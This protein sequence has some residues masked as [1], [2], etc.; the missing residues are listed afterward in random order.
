MSNKLAFGILQNHTLNLKPDKLI[1]HIEKRLNCYSYDPHIIT[2]FEGLFK[3]II[4]KFE[5]VDRID[6]LSRAV[7]VLSNIGGYRLGITVAPLIDLVSPL[8]I[9]LLSNS[10]VEYVKI[11]VDFYR[12]VGRILGPRYIFTRFIAPN[13]EDESIQKTLAIIV[14]QLI[15]DNP[16][17]EFTNDDFGEWIKTL[18]KLDGVGPRL[19]ST[20]K[21]YVNISDNENFEPD[22]DED[23]IAIPRKMSNRNSYNVLFSQNL[24]LNNKRSTEY[25]LPPQPP[26]VT[27]S[28]TPTSLFTKMKSSYSRTMPMRPNTHGAAFQ[29]TQR[30]QQIRKFNDSPFEEDES[31]REIVVSVRNG[32]KSKEWD[33]RCTAYNLARRVLKY[34]TDSFNDDDVHEMVTFILDDVVSVRAALQLAAISAIEELFLNKTEEMEIELARVLPILLRLHSKT[35]QFFEAALSQCCNIVVLSMPSKRFCSVL[36]AIGES[37]SQKVQAASAD[38]YCKSITKAN[39][40]KEK[41]FSKTSD[42]FIYLIK[43]VNKMLNGVSPQIRESARNIVKQLYVFYGDDLEKAAQKNLSENDVNHFLQYT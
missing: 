34:S 11:G 41:F 18:I 32:M 31:V 42:E 12:K 4:E 3:F 27:N 36:L 22:M 24:N 26:L 29:L 33:D 5:G 40:N 1:D 2:D 14:H 15:T 39:E 20:I 8:T 21:Q 17:F 37:K 43:I 35:A 38:L 7:S 23:T 9:K 6:L 28:S 10:Q 30:Q 16:N 25:N 19:S 13:I